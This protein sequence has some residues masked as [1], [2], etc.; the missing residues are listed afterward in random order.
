VTTEATVTQG[1]TEITRRGSA[2]ANGGAETA[3]PTTTGRPTTI[4]TATSPNLRHNTRIIVKDGLA[5]P[6]SLAAFVR[7]FGD[8]FLEQVTHAVPFPEIQQV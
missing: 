8:R 4:E 3:E 6:P 7:A 5:D 1:I 2:R